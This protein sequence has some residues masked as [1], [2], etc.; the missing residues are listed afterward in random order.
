MGI[1]KLCRRVRAMPDVR[2]KPETGVPLAM[3]TL[4][5]DFAGEVSNGLRDALQTARDDLS[6]LIG[7]DAMGASLQG[8]GFD[9][10]QMRRKLTTV[11]VI[12]PA[13]EMAN[14]SRWLR[15]VVAT[16]FRQLQGDVSDSMQSVLFLLDEFLQMGR[17]DVL[18]ANYDQA[19]GLGIQLWPIVQ[20]LTRLK[21]LYGPEWGNFVSG[22][23]MIS[24]FAPGDVFTAKEISALCG[25]STVSVPSG[26]SEHVQ[27]TGL[28]LY[29]DLL[30][31]GPNELLLFKRG[32]E[33]PLPGV[34]NPFKAYAPPYF[35]PGSRFNEGLD[36]RPIGV[37]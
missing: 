1:T 13:R 6:F 25:R 5:G 22:A 20:H 26:R 16:A 31:M 30:R 14:Y 33:P 36:P 34:A 17:M 10:R 29:D 11:Y 12:L 18:L 2:D 27:G 7:S 19:A 24:S 21:A 32:S 8:Q 4:A 23:G 3:K 9:F 37:E 15:L 35:T 28:T